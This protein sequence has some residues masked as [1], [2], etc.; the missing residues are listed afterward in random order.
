MAKTVHG[1]F[2]RTT[3]GRPLRGK[4]WWHNRQYL[5]ALPSVT[6]SDIDPVT[7]TT[8][9][10]VSFTLPTSA[11]AA[12]AARGL[13]SRV[14]DFDTATLDDTG[15]IGPRPA[16]GVGVPAPDSVDETYTTGSYNPTITVTDELGYSAVYT[17]AVVIS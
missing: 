8:S 10:L 1:R 17:E 12:G 11:V 15:T 4:A 9:Q 13:T 16:P 7:G 3:T 14:V 6:G 2:R 5:R